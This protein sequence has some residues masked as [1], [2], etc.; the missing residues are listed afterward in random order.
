MSNSTLPDYEDPPVIET[1]MSVEFAPLAE[2]SVPYFGLFWKTLAPTFQR[3]DVHPSL[4]SQI[5][6]FDSPRRQPGLSVE[7]GLP[8]DVRCW[9]TDANGQSL[10]QVQNNRFVYNWRKRDIPYPHYDKLRPRFSAQW[11]N[12]QQFV[13]QNSLGDMRVL[14]CEITY[15][16]HL[17]KGKGWQNFADLADVISVWARP[18]KGQR[19]LPIP[20]TVT[21]AAA[22]Q[23][24]EK[25][26]RLHITL[27][28]AVRPDDGAEVMQLTLT[29]RGKPARTD[30]EGIL[31]WMDA[32]RTW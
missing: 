8:G 19:F 1:A 26:G 18:E 16:N 30:T 9:F 32:G 25:S 5:E 21:V 3:S 14:Q 24:P 10:I 15:V 28:P 29:A 2:F 12:F 17:E 27:H 31:E 13:T 7:F 6:S 23:M 22:F 20:E 11:E 4:S